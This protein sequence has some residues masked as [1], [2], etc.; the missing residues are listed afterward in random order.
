[1]M[2]EKEHWN[3]IA[4]SYND[5]IFDVFQNDLHKKLPKYFKKH[6]SLTKT[7]I[8]FGCGNG[9]SFPLIAP[10]FKKILG[11]DISKGLLKQAEQRGFKN[12]T[13][14]QADLTKKKLGLPKADFAFCCN[15]IMFPVYEKN[16]QLI[17]NIYDSLK[18]GATA[19]IVLP[20]FDSAMFS[21][22]R[23]IDVYKREGTRATD[24]PASEFKYFKA[25]KRDLIQGIIHIDGVPTKHYSESEI[26][27]IFKEAGFSVTAIDKLEY[28]WETEIALPPAWLKDPYPW[29]WLVE[30]K[31]N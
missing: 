30:L 18:P 5:E 4:P 25:G 31:R 24:I 14:K 23:L 16:D 10:R 7:A 8:D 21:A 19:L 26:K 28:D 17:K 3:K 2:N 12:V 9:K 20:S 1:M 11:L 27:V 6:G 29:D 13:L 15:V 22:W